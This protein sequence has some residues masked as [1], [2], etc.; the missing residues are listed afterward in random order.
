MYHNR[1]DRTFPVSYVVARFVEVI[2]I[3]IPNIL[4][5]NMKDHLFLAEDRQDIFD[6]LM[7]FL[8]FALSVHLG[9]AHFL[10]FG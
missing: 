3:P 7:V 10:Y 4:Y 2:L 8:W 1:Y 6:A 9:S 5:L